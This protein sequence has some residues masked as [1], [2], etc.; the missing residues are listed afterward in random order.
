MVAF[1]SFMTDY[2]AEMNVKV[3]M[4]WRCVHF[5]PSCVKYN[6]ELMNTTKAVSTKSKPDETVKRR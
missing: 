2:N 5:R 6:D 4:R 3:T 1:A